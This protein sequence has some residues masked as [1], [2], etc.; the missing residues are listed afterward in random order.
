MALKRFSA[1]QMKVLTLVSM[2][3]LAGI[4]ALG[5]VA[6]ALGGSGVQFARVAHLPSGLFAS[7]LLIGLALL[8]FGALAILSS[9]VEA[10]RKLP[11]YVGSL[12]AC[13]LAVLG[14]FLVG[15]LGSAPERPYLTSAVF[16]ETWLAGPA[17][18]HV[19]VERAFICCGLLGPGDFYGE[20]WNAS[21]PATQLQKTKCC[22]QMHVRNVSLLTGSCALDQP[23]YACCMET[24]SLWPCYRLR[25][26]LSV[27][28]EWFDRHTS[29]IV[30]FSFIAGTVGLLAMVAGFVVSSFLIDAQHA[31]THPFES[32][33]DLDETL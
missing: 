1:L 33:G 10:I 17:S 13:T 3:L 26:C 21:C 11:L 32:M 8:V 15:F 20:G 6:M 18:A 2:G 29:R 14:L 28:M 30:V 5:L 7:L 31:A 19:G 25:P 27:V 12:V 9:N 23:R 24:T 4:T 22:S 16:E